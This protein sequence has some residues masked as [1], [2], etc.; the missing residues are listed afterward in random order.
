MFDT[1]TPGDADLSNPCRMPL[2]DMV[3]KLAERLRVSGCW[4]TLEAGFRAEFVDLNR[5]LHSKF[6]R[7]FKEKGVGVVEESSGKLLGGL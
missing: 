5:E 3:C 2:G 6:L 1:L 7:K 4:L